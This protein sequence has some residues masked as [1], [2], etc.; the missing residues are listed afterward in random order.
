M[1]SYEGHSMIEGLTPDEYFLKKVSILV[2]QHISQ[3]PDNTEK[4]KISE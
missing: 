3:N 4:K 1:L 2:I